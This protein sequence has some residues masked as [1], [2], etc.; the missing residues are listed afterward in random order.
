MLLRKIINSSSLWELVP[1][2]GLLTL[3][4]A[5]FLCLRLTNKG[6]TGSTQNFQSEG[7]DV[8]TDKQPATR[9]PEH[10]A[11]PI[12]SVSTTTTRPV[13]SCTRAG[14]DCVR[15]AE[16]PTEE[17]SAEENGTEACNPPLPWLVYRLQQRQNQRSEKKSDTLPSMHDA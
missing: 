10:P 11:T 8:M 16:Y 15:Q 14:D 1:S 3:A 9:S 4:H 7:N 17:N 13:K 2:L 12:E 5:S 6:T